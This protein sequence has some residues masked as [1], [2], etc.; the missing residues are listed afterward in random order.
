MSNVACLWKRSGEVEH[1]SGP[2]EKVFSFSPE[3]C[4][5]SSRNGVQNQPGILFSFVGEW[6]S[7]SPGFPTWANPEQ[8]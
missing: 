4:S 7:P 5:P 1:Y 2:A 3:L 6:R 8:F